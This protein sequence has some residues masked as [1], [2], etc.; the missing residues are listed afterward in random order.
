MEE[1]ALRFKRE[2]LPVT[3][4]QF[5]ESLDNLAACYELADRKPEADALRRELA[6]LKARTKAQNPGTG[7]S[8]VTTPKP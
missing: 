2:H 5:H 8:P 6:E 1:A 3:H 4:R 7:P